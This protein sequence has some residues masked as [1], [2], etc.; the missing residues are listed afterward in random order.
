MDTLEAIASRRSIRRFQD[1]SVPEETI[2]IVLEAATRAPSGKNSQPWRFVVVEGEKRAEMVR[3]M[4]QGIAQMQAQGMNTGSAEGT[5]WIMEQAPVTIFC[6]NPNGQAPWLPL[7][8]DQMFSAVVD[9]QSVGAALQ[10]LVLA[11][12]DQ[13]LGSLWMC[14]V[15][16][17]YNELQSWLGEEGQMIAAIALGYAD[18]SPAARPRMNLSQVVRWL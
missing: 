13:G 11:A 17:A 12:Q 9:L 10:N 7:S 4:R 14:D 3:L 6:F 2:R 8:A 15:F 1:K 5:A 18:E 16:Y